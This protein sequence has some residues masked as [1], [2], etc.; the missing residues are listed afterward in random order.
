V[1]HSVNELFAVVHEYYPRARSYNDSKKTEETHRLVQARKRA[2]AECG[3]WDSLLSRMSE[4]LPGKYVQNGSLHLPTGTMD[5]GYAGGLSLRNAPDALSHTVEFRVSFLVPYYFIYCERMV[6]DS[7]ALK[8]HR[9]SS[10]TFISVLIEGVRQLVPAEVADPEFRA[11]EER[12]FRHL[13][14][15]F[16]PS[17]DEAPFVAWIAREIEATFGAERMSPE[18]AAVVVPDVATSSRQLGEATI[19]DCLFT[20]DYDPVKLWKR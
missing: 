12:Q 10:S 1:K 9:D 14:T 19:Y 7:E 16:E 18:V 4:Q 8:A 6:L 15:S 13:I 20:D 3:P 5:A 11:K 2:G 17:P